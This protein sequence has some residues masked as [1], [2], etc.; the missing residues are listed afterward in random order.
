MEVGDAR[1]DIV[2]WVASATWCE[3]V[4]VWQTPSYCVKVRGNFHHTD[5]FHPTKES[6]DR[7]VGAA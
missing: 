7:T 3:L 1:I 2:L 4:P 5:I 6:P